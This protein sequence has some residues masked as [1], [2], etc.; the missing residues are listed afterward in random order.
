MHDERAILIGT[1]ENA[2]RTYAEIDPR[3][4]LI[5]S[6]PD[7]SIIDP[8][9][10]A[11]ESCSAYQAVAGHMVFSGGSGPV[12]HSHALAVHLFSRGVSWGNDIPG[13]VDW[14]L[15]LLTT[16]EAKGLFKAAIWGLSLDQEVTL[17]GTSRLMPFAALPDSYM[18][19][20][21]SER[22]KPCYDG[23][24]WMDQ[25]LYDV[26]LVAYV[27]E[28]PNFPYIGADGACFRMMNEL[29]WQAHALWVLIQA[30]SVGHPLV[31][32]CWFEYADRDL[33]YSEWEN[34][35]TWLLP[36]I[37]PHVKRCSPADIQGIQANIAN[38]RAL[39][40]GRRSTLS[41]SMERFRQS[42]CRREA[43]DRILDLALAFEIAVSDKGD[44]AALGWKVSV[45]STQLIGGPRKER[46]HNRATISA[47]YSLRNQA[48]HGGTLKAIK[49][50][51]DEMLQDNSELYVLLMKRLL[52]LRLKPD[53]K[54]VELEPTGATQMELDDIKIGQKYRCDYKGAQY[55]ATVVSKGAK[56][57]C[58]ILGDIV[59]K[60]GD[61]GD[62]I[63][64]LG[65]LGEMR[66]PPEHLHLM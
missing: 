26:P 25:R 55:F 36:E 48:T 42:Q 65:T 7:S 33:E 1:L 15:R 59:N 5:G 62:P 29:V 19:R 28:V 27:E 49:K 23:S 24:V 51:I 58:V 54:A 16:R 53:W 6:D 31:V 66:V 18:K 17:I 4:T 44:N 39:S 14:L 32:A 37:P 60:D 45:R 20:R 35:F 43:I 38:Y 9:A 57:V 52:A 34:T 2:A 46:K 10:T 13:A 63:E 50:P 40:P 61:P 11:I 12:L 41:R 30:A 8:I 47:L 3:P 22:A 21:I 56:D 64:A